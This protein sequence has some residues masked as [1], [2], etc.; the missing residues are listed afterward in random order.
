MPNPSEI[1]RTYDEN[2]LPNKAGVVFEKEHP[3]ERAAREYHERATVSTPE[4]TRLRDRVAELER[5]VNSQAERIA[6][7][8][9]LLMVRALKQLKEKQ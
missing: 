5:L 4:E 3:A 8:S 9:E 2:G 6:E 1:E 7:Q